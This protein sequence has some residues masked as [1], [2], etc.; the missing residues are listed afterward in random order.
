MENNA[1]SDAKILSGLPVTFQVRK[2]EEEIGA[3]KDD[4]GN[5][6]GI[7]D[8]DR[9]T[10]EDG[11]IVELDWADRKA[12][13]NTDVKS[14]SHGYRKGGSLEPDSISEDETLD[15]AIV[16]EIGKYVHGPYS[17][18]CSGSAQKEVS[19]RPDA[20]AVPPIVF[21]LNSSK[22]IVD[23]KTGPGYVCDDEEVA[24][25][26]SVDDESGIEITEVSSVT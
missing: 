16:V 3:G 11:K 13:R 22:K 24:E 20:G 21:N 23:P 2:R 12:V 17:Q 8:Q 19:E 26:G 6:G 14:A 5:E 25:F 15:V 7:E 4:G 18:P 1:G 10:S 9:G